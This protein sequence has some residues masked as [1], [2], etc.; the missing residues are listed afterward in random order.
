MLHFV[1]TE[2]G[3]RQP[4]NL[5]PSPARELRLHERDAQ[6]AQHVPML[7]LRAAMRPS[8]QELPENFEACA[9]QGA[10]SVVQQVQLRDRA[11]GG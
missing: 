7:P 6:D 4:Q 5:R 8:R 1:A 11:V 3:G 9:D 10:I 2:E